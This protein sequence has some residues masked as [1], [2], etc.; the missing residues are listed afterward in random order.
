MVEATLQD[1]KP[2]RHK[3]LRAHFLSSLAKTHKSEQ[4][5]AKKFCPASANSVNL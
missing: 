3:H 5:E 2:L 1:A 4:A